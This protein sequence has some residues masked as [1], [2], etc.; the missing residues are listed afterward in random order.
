MVEN[1]PCHQV[2]RA[3]SHP[4]T[5]RLIGAEPDTEPNAVPD[6]APEVIRADDLKVFFPIRAGIMRRAV[7]YVRAV[8]GVSFAVRA[9]ETVGLVGESGSGKTT[10]ANA[11]LRLIPGS[12]ATLRGMLTYAGEDISQYG[13]RQMCP[14][15]RHMQIVFQDPFGSLSPRMSVSEIVGEGLAVHRRD[16]DSNERERLVIEALEKVELDPESRHRYPHEFSGGQRQRVALAR[17]L[18]LEPRFLVLDEPTSALD[19]TVQ[20]E[21]LHLLLDLQRREKLAYLF[22]SHDLKV[23]RALCSYVL[24][25][26]RGKVVEHGPAEQVLGQPREKYTQALMAAAFEMKAVT[27]GTV[28]V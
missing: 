16:L 7:D 8:D 20:K 5:I 3:P 17:S 10:V 19:M 21:V 14:L 25:M 1:G 26:Q 23:I 28:S 4:Y 18:V 24:V 2:L 9:G 27:D 12:A 22:I 13:N 6:G 15:R 11:V